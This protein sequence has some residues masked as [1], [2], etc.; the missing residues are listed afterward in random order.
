MTANY[1]HF[2]VDYYP[3]HELLIWKINSKG[4]PN[5]S[6]EGL[7]E[8]ETFADDLQM[9]FADKSYPLKYI[10]S[11]SLHD[12]VYNMGGD[13][14]FFYENIISKNRAVLTEY[15]HSCVTAIYNIYNSFNLPAISVALVEGNAYGGGFEC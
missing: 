10:A 9:V 4:I 3:E 8:F 15:A 13:L 11:A 14:P 7:K 5:F 1:K 2:K 6:L 12:E